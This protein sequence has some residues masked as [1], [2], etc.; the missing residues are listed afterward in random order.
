MELLISTIKLFECYMA[1]HFTNDENEITELHT[2]RI[3]RIKM[4]WQEK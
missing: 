4:L 3:Q 1:F 2:S